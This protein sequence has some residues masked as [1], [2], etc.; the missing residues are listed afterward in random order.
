MSVQVVR[1]TFDLLETIREKERSVSLMQL[2]ES[3]RIPK[4]TVL[5]ILGALEELG[6]VARDPVTSGYVITPQILNFQKVAQWIHLK[7]LLRPLLEQINR[8]FD[9]TVNLA[10]LQGIYVYYLDSIQTSK[11]LSWQV[12]PGAKDVFYTTA[13]GL[14][15]ACTLSEEELSR[16]LRA[17]K[18]SSG[19]ARPPISLRE[20]RRRID[21]TRARGWALDDEDTDAGVLCVGV[22]CKIDE[23]T[24]PAVSLSVPKVRV[25]SAYIKEMADYLCTTVHAFE[26]SIVLEAVETT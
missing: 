8:H 16:M 4:P 1:R 12:T 20:L 23:N 9:E 18:L 3:T 21:E 2:S 19:I 5:R 26:N 24:V 7:H 13:L 15:I 22:H 17:A 10:I 14:S 11:A 25:S 6:Y